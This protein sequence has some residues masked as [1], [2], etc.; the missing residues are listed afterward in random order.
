M[1]GRCQTGELYRSEV[2]RKVFARGVV[3]ATESNECFFFTSSA[4][5]EVHDNVAWD[6]E[7]VGVVLTLCRLS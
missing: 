6:W 2:A 7:E 3:C 1:R 5:R 4:L